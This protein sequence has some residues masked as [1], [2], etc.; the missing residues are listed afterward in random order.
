MTLTTKFANGFI[1]QMQNFLLRNKIK[2][3]VPSYQAEERVME[4]LPTM[5]CGTWCKREGQSAGYFRIKIFA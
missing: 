2:H 3:V 4:W 5:C 1:G